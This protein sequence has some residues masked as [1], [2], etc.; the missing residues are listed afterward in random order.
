MHLDA[1]SLLDL[2]WHQAHIFK[3]RG[4][5]HWQRGF[6]VNSDE[7]RHCFGNVDG[8]RARECIANNDRI[9]RTQRCEAAGH[10][11]GEVVEILGVAVRVIWQAG[12]VF[13]IDN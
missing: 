11:A 2:Y 12:T 3:T 8:E 1:L 7:K 13:K 9:S 10:L 6:T 4:A 5:G